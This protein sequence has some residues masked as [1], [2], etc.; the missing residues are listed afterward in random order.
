MMGYLATLFTALIS[1]PSAAQLDSSS[2]VLL[3]PRGVPVSPE[4]LDSSRYR[5]RAPE[6]RKDD[7]EFEE[8]PGSLIPSPV[9]YRGGR[10]KASPGANAATKKA[11]ATQP[12]PTANPEPL[13]TSPA[14][15]TAASPTAADAQTSNESPT[16]LPVTEQVRELILGDNE[17]IE[18]YRRQVHPEDP[19]AN[20]VSISIAPAYFYDGSSSSYSYR[21]YSTNGPGVGLGMN[22]W[23]TPFF[24]V[25][26]RYFTSVTASV[27]SGDDDAV[28]VDVQTFAAG[29]RFRKHFGYSR[30]AAQLSWGID[31][32]DAMAKISRD[33]TT[34]VGRRSSG[35]NFALEGLVPVSTNYAHSFELGLQPRLHHAEPS[36][37]S[38]ARSG[39]KNETNAVSLSLGGEWTLDRRNQVFWKGQYRV[40]RNLFQGDASEADPLTGKTPSG[41]SVTDSLMMFYFGFKWGS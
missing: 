17:D 15:S 30:R 32:Y 13:L 40:E 4:N 33:A 35:L 16:P 41:V 28:P 8:K 7:D 24:G 14:P 1:L 29:L 26:S 34:V 3:R 5:I 19:R 18:A 39:A 21:R 25:Q 2:A 9:P 6:S 20:V 36:T 27:H 23:L 11:G 37:S 10:A 38:E 31:Y 22:L 12:A